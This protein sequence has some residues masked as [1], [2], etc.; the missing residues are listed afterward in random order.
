MSRTDLLRRVLTL[1]VAVTVLVTAPSVAFA[2]FNSPKAAT[3]SV[4]TASLVTPTNVTGTFVCSRVGSLE[5]ISVTVTGFSDT[6]Q[7][8]GVSYTY[9]VL[10][11][12]S[13][14]ATTSSTARAA[15]LLG[16][17]PQ[18]KLSDTWTI[19]VVARLGGWTSGPSTDTAVCNKGNTTTGS[20]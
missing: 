19:Q 1:V 5:Q 12:G 8:A 2:L 4:S 3:Q 14:R 15:T 17:A 11:S 7:P 9:S 10:N 13:V 16:T 20:F 18:D 6:A